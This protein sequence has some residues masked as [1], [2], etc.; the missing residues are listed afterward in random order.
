MTE[1]HA[2]ALHDLRSTRRRNRMQD[3]HWIDTIYR[4]YV[5]VLGVGLM[6]WWIASMLGTHH[7]G[8]DTARRVAERGPSIVGVLLALALWAAARSGL[9]GGPLAIEAAD[10]AYVLQSP[11]SR[12]TALAR[13]YVHQLRRGLFVGGVVGAIGARLAMPFLPGPASGWIGCGALVG[14]C[15][16]LSW[17]GLAATVGGLRLGRLATALLG[18]SLLGWSIVDV[19][20][21]TATSPLSLLGRVALASLETTGRASGAARVPVA[22]AIVVGV[23]VS[24]ALAALGFVRVAGVVLEKVERRAALVGQLRFAVTTQDL[25]AV[26]LLRRQLTAEH[27][28]R[29]P[30]WRVAGRPG[31]DAAVVVRGLRN[32]A[33][34]PLTRIGRALLCVVIAGVATRA[35]W[36]GA[37]PLVVVGGLAMFVAGLDLVEPLSQDADHPDLI[38]GMPRHRG[39][40]ANRQVIVPVG[41][42]AVLSLVGAAGA[43]LVGP[44]VGA[45]GFGGLPV[46]GGA[47]AF[48]VCAAAAAVLAGAVSVA[49]GPP[50]LATML[51]TPELAFMRTLTGPLL[52]S[53]GLVAPLVSTHLAMTGRQPAALP[54][55][56]RGALV[57]ALV[58]WSALVWLTDG[59]VREA[60]L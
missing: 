25:R 3:L 26:L 35:A 39:R 5:V 17:M 36:E 30:W 46:L 12:R 47:V 52:A 14:A 45:D 42:L 60:N 41:A 22:L 10:L 38:A 53:A 19:A 34:W 16:G 44:L 54:G 32:L 28:R 58:T 48:G 49:M 57:V 29:R 55:L 4:A 20:L 18:A 23:V 59:G 8:T 31:P 9:H 56:V 1:V 2:S 51:T 43:T 6:V 33:R 27:P 24:I 40:L 13:P 15:A 50:S 11:M 7:V 21:R 37:Y